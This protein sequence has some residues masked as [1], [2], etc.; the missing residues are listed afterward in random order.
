MSNHVAKLTLPA[1]YDRLS[2]GGGEVLDE[3]LH[4][5]R[6]GLLVMI[7]AHQTTRC[8]HREWIRSAAFEG[9]AGAP[10][11]HQSASLWGTEQRRE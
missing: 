11:R 5:P 4:P 7:D 6:M 9:H 8:V 2:S 3:S 1:P 10:S